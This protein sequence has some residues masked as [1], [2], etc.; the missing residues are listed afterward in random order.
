M[1]ENMT[2]ITTN[3][4]YFFLNRHSSSQDLNTMTLICTNTLLKQTCH[5]FDDAQYYVLQDKTLVKVFMRQF[6]Q[7]KKDITL[8]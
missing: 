1:A 8:T 4:R 6:L 3:V 2:Y 7:T 5:D